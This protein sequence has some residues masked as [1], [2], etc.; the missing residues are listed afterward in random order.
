M[1]WDDYRVF[2][3]LAEAGSLLK[4]GQELQVS[5]TTVLRRLN[6][7]EERLEVRLFERHKTGYVLT[8]SGEKILNSALYLKDEID[9]VERQVVGQDVR[10]SGEIKISTTDT[11]GFFWLPP[12]IKKFKKLYPDITLNVEVD[13]RHRNLSKREADIVLPSM[14]R[15]PDYMVGRELAPIHIRL[16]AHRSYLSDKEEKKIK[17]DK[18]FKNFDF[19]LLNEN[20]SQLPMNQY[21]L[22]RMDS[23]SV[24]A[25]ASNFSGLYHLCLEGLGV[26]ALPFYV[27]EQAPELQVVGEIP[28]SVHSNSIWILTH[29]DL[30][31]SARIL[32][33]MEF[34]RE[35]KK[36]RP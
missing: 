24:V 2:L 6:S 28:F 26:A 30:I 12:F 33:F 23:K 25:T 27:G 29:P 3:A 20:L 13:N 1:N 5:H 15:Q 17:S 7:L 36:L 31:R 35:Q 8:A 14:N 22:S 4:A 16:Y 19:I 10:L 34:M 32:A 18:S 9:L 11:I 21:I